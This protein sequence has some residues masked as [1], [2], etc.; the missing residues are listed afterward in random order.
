MAYHTHNYCGTTS[1]NDNHDHRYVG[2]TTP[3]QTGVPHTHFI[4]DNTSAD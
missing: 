3:A 2:I 1:F 4:K